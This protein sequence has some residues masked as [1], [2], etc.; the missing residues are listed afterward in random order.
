MPTGEAPKKKKKKKKQHSVQQV[1]CVVWVGGRGLCPHT[2]GQLPLQ[3]S[4][5]KNHSILRA[6]TVEANGWQPGGKVPFRA[7]EAWVGFKAEFPVGLLFLICVSLTT[8]L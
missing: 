7:P 3:I 5:L 1:G 8:F 4:E 2:D 6:L